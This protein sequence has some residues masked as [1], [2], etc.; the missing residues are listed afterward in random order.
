MNNKINWPDVWMEIGQAFE[1]PFN[2][3]DNHQLFLTTISGSQ[4]S[5]RDGICFGMGKIVGTYAIQDLE[6]PVWNDNDGYW[7]PRD[8]KHD[9]IRATFCYFMA[10]MGDEFEDF[11]E[12]CKEN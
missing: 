12:W 11:L 5:C 2:K 7:L 8:N 10:A 9:L 4:T 3:R 1:T 6:F